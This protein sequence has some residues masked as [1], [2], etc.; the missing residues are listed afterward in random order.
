CKIT[1]KNVTVFSGTS[2]LTCRCLRVKITG[3]VRYTLLD[4]LLL[5]LT[6]ELWKEPR[7]L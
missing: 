3:S 2:I 1:R 5:C 7:F 4:P 6:S